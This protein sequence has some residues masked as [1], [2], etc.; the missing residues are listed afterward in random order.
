MTEPA[1]TPEIARLLASL[2]EIAVRNSASAIATRIQAIR[3]GKKHEEAVNEL[4]EMINELIDD[5]NQ[6]LSIARALEE[7]LVAQRITDDEIAYISSTI[8]PTVEKVA[9][10]SGTDGT[11]EFIEPL[12]AL[13]SVETITILQTLGFNFKAAIGD[14]LTRLV[15]AAI[16]AKVPPTDTDGRLRALTLQHETAYFDIVKDPEAFDRLRGGH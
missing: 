15:G 10:L 9:E 11:A 5:K 2:A 3:A 16:L 13:I 14:P 6:L 8:I 12:K 7:K 4:V 1:V